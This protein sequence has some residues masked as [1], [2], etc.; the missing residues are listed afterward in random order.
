ME[1]FYAFRRVAI[2]E[3]D[4]PNY[5]IHRLSYCC[6]GPKPFTKWL[7]VKPA[8]EKASDQG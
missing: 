3:P 7:T 5:L 6:K 1:V 2:E 8:P 4:Y